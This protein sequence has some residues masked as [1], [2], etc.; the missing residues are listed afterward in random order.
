MFL[1]K[2][3]KQNKIIEKNL[4]F[5][6]SLHRKKTQFGRYQYFDCLASQK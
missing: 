5:G 1:N 2:K 3:V 6:S 4:F